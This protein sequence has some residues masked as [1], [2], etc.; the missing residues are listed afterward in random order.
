M[1]KKTKSR[2]IEEKYEVFVA[3]DGTTFDTAS[4]CVEYE[5]NIRMQPV[6]KIHIEKLD[7]LVPLTDGMTC[8]GNEFYWYKVNDEDDFN[9]LNAYYEGKVDEPKEY[10][11]ILCLEVNECYID[12]YLMFDVY[13]YELTDIMESIKEFMEEFRYK[14]KFEKEVITNDEYQY[15]KIK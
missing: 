3:E 15:R 4:E 5:R 9:T 2:M 13:S 8:D 10:P 11:N 1:K 6:S 7:G 12:G 14:V